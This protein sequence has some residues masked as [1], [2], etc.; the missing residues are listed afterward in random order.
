MMENCYSCGYCII[1]SHTY[2]C[3]FKKCNMG[4][5]PYYPDCIPEKA[6]F[7]Y[8]I[9]VCQYI[10]REKE[11]FIYK[12]CPVCDCKLR[13]IKDTQGRI[14]DYFCPHCGTGYE[15]EELKISKENSQKTLIEFL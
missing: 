10:P 11:F 9:R 12:N 5:R 14:I 8:G 6:L 1:G 3:D 7:N 4:G 13:K 2:L 15:E